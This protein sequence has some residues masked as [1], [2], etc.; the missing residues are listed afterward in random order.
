[1]NWFGHVVRMVQSRLVNRIM[2]INRNHTP[3][4]ER[5][6]E[7]KKKKNDNGMDIHKEFEYLL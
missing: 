4:P 2:E 3:T 6:G 1:M 5:V 7:A